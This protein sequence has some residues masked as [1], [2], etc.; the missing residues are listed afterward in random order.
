MKE[1]PQI[2]VLTD[3]GEKLPIQADKL[4]I[5]LDNE[6]NVEIWFDHPHPSGEITLLSYCGE[7]S[8]GRP[9]EKTPDINIT[10]GASNVIHIGICCRDLK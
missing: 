4:L 10:P 5:C 8:A 6:R 9:P 1:K 7:K 3:T 2:F